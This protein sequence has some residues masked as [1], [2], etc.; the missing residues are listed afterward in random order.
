M[1]LR[2]VKPL[3]FAFSLLPAAYLAYALL[4]GGVGLGANPAETLQLET[5]I[6]ALRF[7]LAS[8]AI[9][10]LRRLTGWNRLIQYRRMLGLFAFFYATLHLSTYVVFD[11]YFELAGIM[12]DIAKR[13]YITVGML[14]FT[15]MLPLALTSTK[16]W[17]RRLGRRWQLLHRLVY[18]CAIAACLHFLWKV[19]VMIG[20]PVYYAAILAVLLG[21]R[22]LWRLRS[23]S[24]H[25]RQPARA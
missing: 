8:L 6:W 18:V 20:E 19:K 17:I 10:P 9:T 22:L 4:N 16:G 15:L 1:M 14:A 12:E 21:A 13:P 5:G 3:L 7:L 23:A 24:A 25:V 2:V 11:R